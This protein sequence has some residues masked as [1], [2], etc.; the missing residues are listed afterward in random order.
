MGE[1]LFQG[2]KDVF[3]A[4]VRAEFDSVEDQ[5]LKSSRAIMGYSLIGSDPMAEGLVTKVD[6]TTNE[7]SRAVWRHVGATGIKNLGTRSA[8]GTYPESEFIR[9]YETVVYDPDDQDA[10]QFIVPDE[11]NAKEASQYKDVLNRAKKL[12]YEIDR[13][14][15]AD[16]FE[17]FN[18]AFTAPGS[19]PNKSANRFFGRGNAGLD[20][21]ATGALN[22][23]L[24]ST[25]HARADGGHPN[26]VASLGHIISPYFRKV[27]VA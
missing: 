20:G 16:I 26:V 14:N 27:L 9:G 2:S 23:E 4:K 5:A 7:G 22:E 3:L 6:D 1:S 11:R 10:G 18:L 19:Y 8:G 24:A 25:S 12:L 21:A 15:V 13:K 17:I